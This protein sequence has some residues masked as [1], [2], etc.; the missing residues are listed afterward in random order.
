MQISGNTILVTG[1]NNGIGRRLAEE[2]ARRGNRVII[3]GRNQQAIDEVVQ[4]HDGIVAGYRLDMTDAAAIRDFAARIVADHPELNAV[5]NNAG[6][7]IA[8]DLKAQD[9]DVAEATVATN[10]LGPIR[11]TSAL[12]PHLLTKDGAAVMT[13]S[14][15]LAFVPLAATPTYCATKAAIHSY[16]LSL[17]EQL[18]DT[19][20]EVIEIVPPGVQTDLMPGHAT[21]PQ[22]MPLE[23]YIA[24]TMG[25]FEQTPMPVENAVGRVHFLY[26]ATEQGRF[27][28]TFFKLNSG[29]RE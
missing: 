25:I 17:R 27:A 24:E 6:I 2:F 11:L 9:L 1:G 18:K 26:K 7:M 20:V 23:D 22:M 14:S 8:E 21:N 15:G 13:V 16:S 5:I 10:L 4:A 29:A 3:S 12:L 28:D 19:N